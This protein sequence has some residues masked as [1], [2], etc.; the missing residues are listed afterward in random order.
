MPHNGLFGGTGI[1][2][3]PIQPG[4]KPPPK[5]EQ[6]LGPAVQLSINRQQLLI[7]WGGL[8]HLM[9]RIKNVRVFRRW[10]GNKCKATPPSPPPF[11]VEVETGFFINKK[12]DYGEVTDLQRLR[13]A[14]ILD[15]RCRVSWRWVM[16]ADESQRPMMSDMK[17][18]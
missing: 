16:M 8:I 4:K 9:Q 17:K 2:F 5:N 10:Q 12:V 14:L 18:K 11:P 6:P 15:P 7:F 13:F 3:K 1:Q